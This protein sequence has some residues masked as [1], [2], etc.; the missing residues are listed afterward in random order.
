MCTKKYLRIVLVVG[1]LCSLLSV[2]SSLLAQESSDPPV[3]VLD[4]GHGWANESGAIDP[5]A[6]LGDLIEK[7]IN[8][9]VAQTT[10][11]YLERCDVDVY[12]TRNGDDAEHTLFDVDEI[13]N[14]YD[15]TVG[16]SIHTNSGADTDSGTEGWYTEGGYD[17]QQSQALARIL[18]DRISDRLNIPNKGIHGET[19]NRHGGLYIHHWQTPSA[20]VEIGYVQGDADLLRNERDKFAQAIAQAALEFVGIDPGCGD[21]AKS[22]E[23]IVELFIEGETKTNEVRLRNEGIVAWEPGVYELRNIGDL[24]GASQSYPLTE[25]VEVGEEYSWQIPATA[26]ASPGIE[27]QVWM[28]YR[29]ETQV[30]E[31]ASVLMVII[32]EEAVEMREDFQQKIDEW[33]EQGAQEV[34][35]LLQE[36]KQSITQWLEDQA[37]Q[38]VENCLNGNAAIMLFFVGMIFLPRLYSGRKDR[39]G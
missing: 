8:L 16:I 14:G 10:K 30:D 37:R 17:D 9:E 7:D 26:P 3:I 24:Y 28:L 31:E 21:E 29:N 19:T 35:K 32:P 36:L 27:E 38:G 22:V 18:P 1:L 6:V 25:R 5:G 2:S 20:L 33:K 4:P 11:A 23:V 15:P 34:D 12:L 39:F 13:V